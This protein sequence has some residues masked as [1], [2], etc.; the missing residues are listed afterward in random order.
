MQKKTM[1]KAVKIILFIFLCL[2]TSVT[3]PPAGL[4]FS[5]MALRENR[6]S[7]RRFI[8]K[9]S[10]DTE[11]IIPALIARYN[12]PKTIISLAIFS[13]AT[14]VGFF[15]LVSHLQTQ[16]TDDYVAYILKQVA[17]TGI[18]VTGVTGIAWV[19][20]SLGSLFESLLAKVGFSLVVSA[21]I[22]FSRLNAVDFFAANFP[23]PPSY[24]PFS[25][26]LAT[27]IF[28]FSFSAFAFA[29][30][31][32]VFEIFFMLFLFIFDFKN[33]KKTTYFLFFIS[34]A[35]FAGSYSAAQA[36]IQGISNKG[37]LFML[38]A[39][40][41]YDFTT[42]HM[43]QTQEGET[44]LFIENVADRAIAATFPPPPEGKKIAPRDLSDDILKTYLPTNFRT[45]HCNP[46]SEP[47]QEPGWCG[48]SRGF[49][50][51]DADRMPHK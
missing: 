35:G 11:K 34:F 1:M 32:I 50:F 39:A 33:H 15:L 42:N 10:P 38:K 40:E 28:A 19:L 7:I 27:L 29:A 36:M 41:R 12:D 49:G 44:V 46:F 17:L 16:E 5:Y 8:I 43:C 9:T 2:A 4:I 31:A 18:L 25:F 21:C 47:R 3:I 48:N 37:P 30:L 6:E 23:F 22:I 45:V 20:F 14:I 24:A 51:C 13:I 26:G